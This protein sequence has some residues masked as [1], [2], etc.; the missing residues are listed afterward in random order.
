MSKYRGIVFD[1]DGTII[2]NGALTVDSMAVIN[3]FKDIPKNVIAIAATGRTKSYTLPII[4]PLDLKHA[5]V[6]ANG[7]Q[8]ISSSS[9]RTIHSQNISIDQVKSV[10][11]ICKP[12]NYKLGPE[13]YD[14]LQQKTTEPPALFLHNINAL[15][16]HNILNK[17]NSIPNVHAYLAPAWDNPLN[18]DI[19]IGH[20]KAKKHV[21]IEILYK[22]YNLKPEEV[23]GIGD[24]INDI[25][26]F[27]AVGHKIAVANANPKLLE[28]ADEIAPSQQ[29]DGIVTVIN[30]YF[31]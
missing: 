3:A 4:K 20:A 13:Q 29:E 15:D 30:K 18:F 24:G 27:N 9:G 12:Y 16:T 31:S 17:I 23:I 28:Q 21:A 19:G 11:A 14:V 7:A 22:K 8:I 25:E 1:I 26:L 6:V 5:S 10:F 2:P